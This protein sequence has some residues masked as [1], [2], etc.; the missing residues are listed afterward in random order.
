MGFDH[1]CDLHIGGSLSF[2]RITVLRFE[3]CKIDPG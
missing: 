1:I 2:V 3:I